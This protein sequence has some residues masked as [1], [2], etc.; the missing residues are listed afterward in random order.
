MSFLR[1]SLRGSFWTLL[2]YAVAGS[3]WAQT[4]PTRSQPLPAGITEVR[5]VEGITELNLRNGLQLL[6]IPDDSKPTTTVNLTYRVGSRHEGY[7][8]TGMAHLLEHLIFKGTPRHPT[9]WAEFTKRGLQ[10]NGSTWL[11]RTNYMA[12]FA[13]DDER[14]QWYLGWLADSMVN[15]FIAKK[16]LD[17]EMTV[18]RNEME[19]GE[20]NGTQVLVEK[21]LASMYQWHNYGKSTIGARADVENVDIAR[22]Q[23]FYR[24]HYQPDNATLIVSGK[25]PREK[26]LRWVAESFGR[27]AKPTR[28]L[29]TLYTLDPAQ[30]GERSV[31]LR[32]TGGVPTVMAAYHGVAGPHPDSAAIELLGIVLADTPAGRLHKALVDT[33]L[34]SATFSWTPTFADPGF[35]LFGAQL[36]PDGDVAKVAPLLLETLEATVRSPITDGEV[37]RARTKWLNGWE[38]AFTNP[39]VVGV[40]LSESIAQG[41]WRLFFLQRDRVRTATTADVQRVAGQWLVASNRTVGTYLPTEKPARAPAPGRV[42]LAA[43][44]AGFK[45][46]QAAAAVEA[47]DPSP[48]NIDTRTQRFRAGGVQAAVLPKGARGGA[49]SASL[50]LRFGDE[51]TLSNQGAVPTFVANMLDKGTR[52]MSRQ[53]IQDRLDALKTELAFGGGGGL[54]NVRLQTRREFL[55]DAIRLVGQMLREPSFPADVLEETRRGWLAQIEQS[56]REPDAALGNAVSRHVSPYPKGDPRYA[57]TFDESVADVQ[58]V[59]VDAMK[60]FHQRFYGPQRATFGAVGDMDAAAVRQALE[61]AF[62]GWAAGAAFTRV[63]S[64]FVA[65]KPTRIVVQTPDKQNANML[66]SMPVALNDTAADYPAFMMANYLL[67]AGGNS[68]LWKRIRETDGLSYDV[69]TSMNWNSYEAHS[70]WTASAIFAPQNQAKVEAAFKEE[71][72]RALK[73]GFT[74]QELAEGQKGL[75]AFRRLGRSQDT[76]LAAVLNSNLVLDRTLALAGRVDDALGKLSLE[77]VNAALRKYLK[78]EDFVVGFGGDFKQP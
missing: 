23:A 38:Q 35:L 25:F 53:Q 49:V 4:A 52:T 18:V 75:L 69:R 71:V 3:A 47:F 32:R 66:V 13:T 11:D 77:Q 62:G 27:I 63:P 58:A 48:A 72:A 60:A 50:T 17:T 45:P 22:L 78:T 41:D 28:K 37:E 12:S 19:M 30:D 29:P 6:L 14:L 40:S 74:A 57:P 10:A 24:L 26:T 54:V 67:G 15:S 51:T 9:V 33:Q 21:M 59:T 65:P 8:E 16:D 46:Q 68:R 55:P 44:M 73:D 39:E 61:Q 64:P 7:G 20:N 76:N 43:Q 42:D 36:A 70:T 5:S 2:W 56:R 1:L 31:T 34:A